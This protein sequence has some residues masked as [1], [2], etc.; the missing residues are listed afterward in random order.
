[1]SARPAQL[2]PDTLGGRMATY[3]YLVCK[4][5]REFIFL[6]KWLH[7]AD[8]KGFGF[9]HGTLCGPDERDGASLGRKALRFIARHMDHDLMAASEGRRAD[10]INES[11][12]YV[13]ADDIY[14]AV[15]KQPDPED[16]PSPRSP[17]T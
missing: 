13:C 16:W 10:S 6:G 3:G 2:K 11:V 14:D 7:R 1:M 8:D 5:C 17:S 15:A 9:W 12:E 4:T